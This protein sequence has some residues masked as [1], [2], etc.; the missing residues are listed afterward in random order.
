MSCVCGGGGGGGALCSPNF[1]KP[2]PGEGCELEGV[3]ALCSPI[4]VKPLPG[5]GCE[6][7]E[8]REGWGAV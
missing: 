8:L 5:E 7:E 1:I 2:L 4:L 6:I 3:G